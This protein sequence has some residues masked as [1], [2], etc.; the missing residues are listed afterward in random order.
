MFPSV[1]ILNFWKFCNF[2]FFF[3]N[4]R[5]GSAS[6]TFQ[7]GTGP[8]WLDQVECQ[9]SEASIERC[10]RNRWGIHDCSHSEDAGVECSMTTSKLFYGIVSYIKKLVCSLGVQEMTYFMWNWTERIYL[11]TIN[12]CV[13][14]RMV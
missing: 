12:L 1:K 9:G 3:A 10:V 8:I 13:K 6:G 11:F 4:F 5:D 14:K 7:A 2:F